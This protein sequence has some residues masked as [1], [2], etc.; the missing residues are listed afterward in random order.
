MAIAARASSMDLPS[1][2]GTACS[3]PV[4]EP[5]VIQQTEMAYP[6]TNV[7]ATSPRSRAKRPQG[8][9]R[10]EPNAGAV[11]RRI[12]MGL[13][14]RAGSSRRAGA[15]PRTRRPSDAAAAGSSGLHRARSGRRETSRSA[16]AGT[17]GDA[18]ET[19]STW[20]S[21]SS[22]SIEHVLYTQQAAGRDHRRGCVEQLRLPPRQRG[23][24]LAASPAIARR[25]GAR[26]SRCPRHG[27]STS[28][29]STR[30]TGGRRRPR[31]SAC[32]RPLP[33]RPRFSASRRTR[34]RATSPA[35]THPAPRPSAMDFPPGAAH[36]SYTT[37]SGGRSANLVSSA[38][39]GSCTMNAPS[40]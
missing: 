12:L 28:T 16:P 9:L 35:I 22:G 20:R 21:F 18:P 13:A 24:R 27:A 14:P 7:S 36:A 17:P 11:C 25:D 26:M 40:S 37:A 34:A 30:R 4:T 2:R 23:E 19:R 39:A 31:R 15:A 3:S 29:A 10:S 1:T 33:A 5:G 6:T 8:A 32:S 38:C